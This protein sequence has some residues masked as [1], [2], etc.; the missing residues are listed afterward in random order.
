MP[1]L[2][3]LQTLVTVVRTG[4]LNAAAGELGLS[5]QAASERMK[6]LETRLG[7]I[8][9]TRSPNGTR[10]TEAG[11]VVVEW[12]ERLLAAAAEFDTGVA[13][14]RGERRQRLQI[15]ASLTVAEHLLPRWLVT[16]AG[17]RD[18]GPQV[19]FVA[20]NS[21][22]VCDLVKSGEAELGF[23]EGPRVAP[24]VRDGIVAFDDLVLVA[25]PQHRWARRTDPV[26]AAELAAT[27]LVT[28]ESG[29]GTRAF[30]EA[31]LDQA[32]G[33]HRTV[34]PPALELST[35]AAVRSAVLAGAG[36]AVL[37]RLSVRDDLGGR[38]TEV[39]IAADLDLRRPLRAVW[40]SGTRPP[41]GAAREFFDH[42]LTR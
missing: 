6:A 28:R 1:D 7:V 15:A 36:P 2:A 38:L 21:E 26:P 10:P 22:R 32:L 23:I 24:G 16:F 13:A 31:A 25:P 30:F 35:T 33:A 11:A 3:S 18:D 41:A 29:S 27:A 12:A 39:P 20:A 40:L 17:S 8:L 5:Q 37:S 9:L 4:S 19:S 34:T 42:I 14:L